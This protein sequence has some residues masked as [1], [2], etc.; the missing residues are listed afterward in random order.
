M[1]FRKTAAVSAVAVLG[2]LA[3]A[4][5]SS[6]TKTAT[7]ASSGSASAS[8]AASSSAAASGNVGL[9][10]QQLIT[11]FNAA[12]AQATAVHVKGTE[13]SG[14]DKSSLDLQLNK[15][16]NSASGTVASNGA[17]I[18]IISVGGTEYI[19]M[20]DSLLKMSGN[21][22]ASSAALMKD[23][24]VS[25]KSSTGASLASSFAQFGSFDGFVSSMT[26]STDGLF[27]G[28]TAAGTT[29]YNGQ[30]VAVYKNGDGSTSYFA[31]TGPAYVIAVLA[32]GGGG[33]GTLDFT[34]NQPTTV[35]APPASQIL[36]G[37]AG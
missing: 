12:T 19:Q 23:K 6:S 25:S 4:G 22:P 18:P 8:A 17:T 1:I 13:V 5:C 36:S 32:P 33:S 31:A 9:T 24:W 15:Q 29:T 14:T 3:V 21:I 34:W 20:T 11:A 2:V 10:Q 35:S 16:G 30:T 26:S 27:T 7:A 37:S 28:A